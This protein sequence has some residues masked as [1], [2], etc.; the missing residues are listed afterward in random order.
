MITDV[1][2]PAITQR[3]AFMQSTCVQVHS[4]LPEYGVKQR[5][6]GLWREAVA[7]SGQRDE[8]S[9]FADA[10]QAALFALLRSYKDVLLPDYPYPQR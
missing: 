10:K 4:S 5:L 8:D 3:G 1:N 9:D 6:V 7:A 2:K